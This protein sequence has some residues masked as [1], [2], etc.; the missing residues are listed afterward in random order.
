MESGHMSNKSDILRITTIQL[1][2]DEV[3]RNRVKNDN[4]VINW[5]INSMEEHV[6]N[7]VVHLETSKDIWDT[8]VNLYSCTA[9]LQTVYDVFQSMLATKQG[10]NIHEFLARFRD[11]LQ[12][13]KIAQPYSTDIRW[14]RHNF[15]VPLA[16]PLLMTS[17]LRC[18]GFLIHLLL[19]R[20]MLHQLCSLVIGV[21]HPHFKD[22][23]EIQE[24]AAI[25]VVERVQPIPVLSLDSALTVVVR[26]TLWIHAGNS[27]S[28]TLPGPTAAT[29]IASSMFSSASTP[30]SWII[31]SGASKHLSVAAISSTIFEAQLWHNRLG[32]PSTSS[33]HSLVPS[34]KSLSNNVKEYLF[35]EFKLFCEGNGLLHQTSCAYTPQQNGVAERKNRHLLELARGFLYSMLMISWDVTFFEDTSFDSSHE[36][37][38]GFRFPPTTPCPLVPFQE[39]ITQPPEAPVIPSPMG[40]PIHLNLLHYERNPVLALRLIQLPILCLLIEALKH[41]RWKAA[42]DEEMYALYENQTWTLT[43]LPKRKRP[44][45]CR[46]RFLVKHNPDGSVARLQ[47]RLVAKGYTQCYGIDYEETFSPVAKLNSIRIILSIVANSSWPVYQLDLEGSVGRWAQAHKLKA[48]SPQVRVTKW[49]FMRLGNQAFSSLWKN[50]QPASLLP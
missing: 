1:R 40:C 25:E 24:E 3:Y 13:W 23:V 2:E 12:E 5:L 34:L 14:L 39:D 33:L 48:R 11:L 4:I 50:V 15:L 26:T 43:S 30:S 37:P 29:T 47:T 22:T 28:S 41:S 35:N 6:T 20:L 32:H 36:A 9:S 46:W 44:V 21:H 27:M 10:D 8:Y 17:V 38:L 7:N 18:Y 42:M 49:L 45:G 19:L 16:F 31:D